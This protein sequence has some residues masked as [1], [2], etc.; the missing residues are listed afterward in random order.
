M[1]SG[2]SPGT[3]RSWLSL[4][5]VNS[6]STA[7]RALAKLA[8]A[9]ARWRSASSRLASA[10][11][12]RR[13]DNSSRPSARC[14]WPS[15]RRQSTV[16]PALAIDRIR[17]KAASDAAGIGLRW[18]HRQ[19]RSIRRSDAPGSA[20]R[21]GNA[22]GP[23]PSARP[24]RSDERVP[25]PIAFRT[26]VSR[27]RGIPGRSSRG[28]GGLVR[29]HL[30]QPGP[31]R[32]VEERAEGE[33]LVERR[34]QRID[35]AARVGLALEPLRGHVAERARPGRRSRSARRCPRRP[36]PGRSRSPRPY[37]RVQQQVR[38]LDVS[39]E[40]PL[41]MGIGQGL[42]DVAADAGHR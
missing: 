15:A 38:R 34:A 28:T 7:A 33:Q 3:S 36:W 30:H 13:S 1:R 22:A 24:S 6:S 21:R 23:R 26:I 2:W 11:I 19:T 16:I 35:V 8:S 4:T 12:R 31:V 5:R 25:W 20:G 18:L 37:R 29:H 42:G 41:G 9:A 40:H 27:S 39:V 17:N 14:L 32:L 10:S